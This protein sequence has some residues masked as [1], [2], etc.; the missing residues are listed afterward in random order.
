MYN[1]F[2]KNSQKKNAELNK[3]VYG[4]LKQFYCSFFS[5]IYNELN[6]EK[7][8]KIRDAIGLVMQKFTSQDNPLAYTGKLVMYIQGNLAMHHLRLTDEQRKLLR[9][10]ADKTKKIN[11]NYVYSGPITDVHQFINT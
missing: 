5:N 10:I 8:K 7:Y 1:L 9:S 4:E 3:E 11:L 6:I 2:V